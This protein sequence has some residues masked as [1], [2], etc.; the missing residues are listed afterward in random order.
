M[1]GASDRV[2]VTV[3]QTHKERESDTAR[4]SNGEMALERNSKSKIHIT[5]PDTHQHT[6]EGRLP[7]LERRAEVEKGA[8]G[9]AGGRNSAGGE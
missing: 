6:A 2:R 8:R 1:D 3:W 5:H 9:R 4:H 7:S